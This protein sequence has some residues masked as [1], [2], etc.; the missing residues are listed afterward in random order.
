MLPKYFSL[1]KDMLIIRPK[2]I[3]GVTKPIWHIALAAIIG[4]TTLVPYQW[5]KSLQLI[6]RSGA[7]RFH[8]RVPDLQTSCRDL[9]TWQGTRI[10]APVMAARV[11]CPISSLSSPQYEQIPIILGVLAILADSL[12]FSVNNIL[13]GLLLNCI[14]S[15]EITLFLLADILLQHR[16]LFSVRV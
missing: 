16:A 5:V 3:C 8:L 14:S 6:W 2:N 10:V 12:L 4:T 9:T 1:S 7:R 15:V 11:T 13:A